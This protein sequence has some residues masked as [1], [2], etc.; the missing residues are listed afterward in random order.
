MPLM[1]SLLLA[2]CVLGI[3]AGA[4]F[5]HRW[6]SRERRRAILMRMPLAPAH[7]TIIEQNMPVYGK[8]PADLRARLDRLIQRFLDEIEFVGRDGFDVCTEAKVTIAAQAC[9]LI[10]GPHDRWFRTLDKVIVYPAPFAKH[11]DPVEKFFAANPDRELIG[12]SWMAGPVLLAWDHAVYGCLETADGENLLIHEFAHQLDELDGRGD[13]RPPLPPDQCKETWDVI[14][15]HAYERLCESV[16]RDEPSVFDP[17][18]S[19]NRAEFFA[20]TVESFFEKPADVKLNE[21]QIF[22]QLAQYF[23][24][25]PTAW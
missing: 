13:G 3:A 2:F 1:T 11:R 25:D 10:A 9:F 23:G 15:Q 4:V 24:F 6:R 14:F 20:I 16:T 18:G 12:E 22:E 19:I 21:P 8:L 7:Q 17:Y 5:Y